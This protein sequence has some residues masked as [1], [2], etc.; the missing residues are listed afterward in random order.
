MK[1][2]IFNNTLALLAGSE[3][4]TLTLATELKRLGHD[5]TSYSPHLGLIATKLEAL[6]IKCVSELVGENKAQIRPFNPILEE[7][8]G[9]FDI[10]IGAHYDRTKEVR[11]KFPNLPIIAICH[12]ILHGN[13]ETGEIYPEHPVTNIKNIQ[14]VAV[15]EEIQDLLKLEY[16]IESML[17]RN[18]FDLEKFKPSEAP[19]EKIKT[20]MVSSNYWG[21]ES[22]INQVIKEVADHYQARF[23]GVG[24]NF[25]TTSETHEVMKDADVVFGMGR[26]V[27][28]GFCMGKIAVV[29]GRWGTGGVITPESYEELKKTNFSGRKYY[30]ETIAEPLV[31]PLLSSEEIINQINAA[32]LSTEHFSKTQE[33]AKMKHNVRISVQAFLGAAERLIKK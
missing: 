8:E 16:G 7:E 9:K 21:V 1:I 3:T 30:P 19:I 27:M 23:I 32:L 24:A 18:F 29:H 13:K 12:G 15:S 4:Y 28:E 14:Y 10:A 31:Q 25:V 11:E 17:I 33:I 2:L 26:S 20:I 6:G 22:P 5:V